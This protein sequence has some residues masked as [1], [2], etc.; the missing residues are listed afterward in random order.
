MGV[1][2]GVWGRGVFVVVVVFSSCFLVFFLN[3]LFCVSDRASEGV[4]IA[5]I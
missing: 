1:I 3:F 4:R 2:G 5:F